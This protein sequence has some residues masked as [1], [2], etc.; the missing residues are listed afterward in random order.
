MTSRV[1]MKRAAATTIALALFTA[2]LAP[3]SVPAQA[4]GGCVARGEYQAAKSAWRLEG[5]SLSGVHSYFGFKGTLISKRHAKMTR[6]YRGCAGNSG[7]TVHYRYVQAQVGRAW[8]AVR[9]TT[10]GNNTVT[11]CTSAGETSKYP[12][13]F[14]LTTSQANSNNSKVRAAVRS[15]QKALRGLGIQDSNG[16]QVIID[17]SYGSQTATA[18]RRF[19]QRTGITVDGK[20]G[21]QTWGSLGRQYC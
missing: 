18:V 2:A 10:T 20:V 6:R 1:H 8:M 9:F 7:V 13:N 3:L 4:S 21:S 14:L 16:Q 15:V 5:L 19:Q 11:L 12:F 17:G